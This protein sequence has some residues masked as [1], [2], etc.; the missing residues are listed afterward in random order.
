MPN[1]D[2][3]KELNI[4][5]TKQLAL[6]KN[7]QKAKMIELKFEVN[8]KTYVLICWRI[9]FLANIIVTKSN[10]LDFYGAFMVQNFL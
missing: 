10:E 5:F 6:L 3:R 2:I 7:L 9:K 8:K 1:D 4:T